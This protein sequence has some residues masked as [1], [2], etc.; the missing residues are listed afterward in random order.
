[1]KIVDVPVYMY[2]YIAIHKYGNAVSSK[3]SAEFDKAV[4]KNDDNHSNNS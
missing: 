1:M 3:T 2:V 4:L